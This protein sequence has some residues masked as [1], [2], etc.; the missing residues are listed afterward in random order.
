MTEKEYKQNKTFFWN[1]PWTEH[2]TEATNW[3][4]NE[5]GYQ[6]TIIADAMGHTVA[7]V[8]PTP[9]PDALVEAVRLYLDN[10]DT[11]RSSKLL[12][13]LEAALAAHKKA[14]G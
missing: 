7:V 12:S 2:P 1:T 10:R 8:D 11:D 6:L 4:L 3:I 14:G 9:A 13:E 5:I